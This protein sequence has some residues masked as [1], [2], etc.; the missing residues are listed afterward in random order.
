MNPLH[1]ILARAY[2]ERIGRVIQ[3]QFPRFFVTPACQVRNELCEPDT[4]IGEYLAWI[5][6]NPANDFEQWLRRQVRGDASPTTQGQQ[7]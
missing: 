7:P 1:P 5:D 3:H 6:Q 4:C 2:I